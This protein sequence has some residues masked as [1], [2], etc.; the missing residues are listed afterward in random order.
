MKI[1]MK[2][3]NYLLFQSGELIMEGG[4]E[5]LIK[6]ATNLR[7][8]FPEHEY[9][10]YGL[11]DYWAA[12]RAKKP[13]IEEA[14]QELGDSPGDIAAALEERG[15]KG[16][17]G[18]KKHCPIAKYINKRIGKDLVEVYSGY[19]KNTDSQCLDPV[20]PKAVSE[21]IKL[22]DKNSYPNLVE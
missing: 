2:G 20:T 19:L 9:H 17:I 5:S 3:D 7:D 4:R 16:K 1:S 18:N 13:T 6:L 14:L 12:T 8:A 11:T 15:I 22:F 21:F 10:I